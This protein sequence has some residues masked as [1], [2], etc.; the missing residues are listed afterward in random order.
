[1]NYSS[2][3]E[4]EK[5][6]DG[7]AVFSSDDD[8]DDMMNFGVGSLMKDLLADLNVD[9]DDANNLLSLE[10]LEN[11]L[12]N[13][14]AS[15]GT[16][17]PFEGAIPPSNNAMT[18]AA[19]MV[20]NSQAAYAQQLS[21]V[22]AATTHMEATSPMDAWSL[23]LQKFTASS[24]EADFLQADSARKAASAMTLPPPGL[25]DAAIDYDVTET[26]TTMAPPPGMTNNSQQVISQAAAKLVQQL[27]TASSSEFALKLSQGL[28]RVSEI[29]NEDQQ[30]QTDIGGLPPTL[31]HAVP[32]KPAPMTPQNSMAYSSSSNTE[33]PTPAP[34]PVTTTTTGKPVNAMVAA[35]TTGSTLPPPPVVVPVLAAPVVAVPLPQAWQQ[36]QQRP[37]TVVMF[38]NPHPSAPPI[39]AT[40]LSSRFMT[41]RD[42]SYV[43]HGMLRPILAAETAGTMSTYH[44]E[45]WMRHHP[46][47]PP[48]PATANKKGKDVITKEF[49]SREKVAKQWSE[50]HKTLGPPP[51]PM[52]HVPVLS[53]R[54]LLLLLLCRRRRPLSMKT[55]SSNVRR[56]GNRA[57]T[58]IR[59]TKLSSASCT[60]M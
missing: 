42:I 51:R 12:R 3:K 6:Q 5:Q 50:M 41:A 60:L 54:R 19:G 26:A 18:S 14:E 39:P 47:K 15:G 13:L 16:A 38:A 37:T 52:W 22:P 36:Q 4:E 35:A 32:P 11:E 57:F 9:E 46:V 48:P 45:F 29:V 1:M 21:P 23:S 25:L 58:A 56:F 44:L 43:V 30:L 10:Q 2:L 31:Q 24:L 55:S 28:G 8:D 49:A 27:T 59:P 7:A 34:T 20:V 53:F 40:V 17:H 33:T